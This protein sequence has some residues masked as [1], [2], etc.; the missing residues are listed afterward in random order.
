MELLR[1]MMVALRI[2][3]LPKGSVVAFETRSGERYTIAVLNPK[4]ALV[5]IQGGQYK[6]RVRRILGGSYGPGAIL[7][8]KGF[9][10]KGMSLRTIDPESK[11]H[12]L[13]YPTAAVVS[14]QIIEEKKTKPRLPPFPKPPGE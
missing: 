2:N 7:W 1:E 11:F 5:L 8:R 4:E 13:E 6:T 14:W 12:D 3:E 9:V 10:R